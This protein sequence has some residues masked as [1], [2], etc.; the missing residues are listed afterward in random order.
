MKSLK[1][2]TL[3]FGFICFAIG[4]LAALSSG[5]PIEHVI[6]LGQTL[7]LA[8]AILIAAAVIS[9]AIEGRNKA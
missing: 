8:G 1:T 5:G 4:V 2:V 6:L 7:V 9:S 3:V